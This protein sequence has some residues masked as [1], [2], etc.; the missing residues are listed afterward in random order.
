MQKTECE[1]EPMSSYRCRQEGFNDVQC[2]P[3][4]LLTKTR[5]AYS[6][7][8][9]IRETMICRFNEDESK[10]IKHFFGKYSYT[11]NENY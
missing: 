1:Y 10:Y 4:A 3:S 5:K 7:V 9:H 8:N 2:L 6:R 11:P